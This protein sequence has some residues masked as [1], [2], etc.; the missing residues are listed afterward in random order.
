MFLLHRVCFV[1]SARIF[2]GICGDH[3]HCFTFDDHI[4][5]CF[6]FPAF[7]IIYNSNILIMKL[8]TRATRLLGS[9]KASRFLHDNNGRPYRACKWSDHCGALVSAPLCFFLLSP[10]IFLKIKH[11]CRPSFMFVLI[12]KRGLK[13]KIQP[14][15]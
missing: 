6:L 5:T 1:C 8:I 14:T 11:G 15:F 13:K 2:Q 10:L 12:K 9:S 7:T 4:T 3:H